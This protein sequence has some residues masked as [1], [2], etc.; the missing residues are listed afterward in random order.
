MSVDDGDAMLAMEEGLRGCMR[1]KAG[2]ERREKPRLPDLGFR[3]LRI[4][5]K[6]HP[7]VVLGGD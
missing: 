1:E 7:T 3:C 6:S 2:E 4:S 5:G